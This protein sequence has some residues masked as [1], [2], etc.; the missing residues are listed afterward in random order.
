MGKRILIVEDEVNISKLIEMNLHLSGYETSVVFDG[1]AAVEEIKKDRYDLVL[2]DVMLPGIDGFQ[3]MEEVRGSGVPVIFLTAKVNVLDRVKGLKLGADDYMI[4]PFE[5]IELLARVESVLRRAGKIEPV[6]RFG[7][8][9][10]QEDER[11]VRK[12]GK[13]ID[14][15]LKEYELLC[16]FLR[17]KNI[18]LSREQILDRVWDMD[19]AGGTRTVDVHVKELRKKLDLGDVIKTVYKIGYRW[20]G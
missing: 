16:M 10:V 5:G 1:L 9:E 19:F 8:I 14:L 11:C 15:T 7:H 2:L 20:E 18:A 6:M 12:N 3:V 4:K 13:V 17:N